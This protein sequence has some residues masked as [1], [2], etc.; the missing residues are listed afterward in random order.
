LKSGDGLTVI[1]AERHVDHQD[2]A[3]KSGINGARPTLHLET[4]NVDERFKNIPAGDHVI[5]QPETTH[6]GARWFVVKDPDDNLIAF[7]GKKK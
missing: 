4:D 5:V 6:W 3:W 1:L 7:N 2:N